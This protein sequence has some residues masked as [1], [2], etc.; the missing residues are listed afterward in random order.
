MLLIGISIWLIL[1]LFYSYLCVKS[2]TFPHEIAVDF[3]TFLLGINL[4]QFGRNRIET[5]RFVYNTF[6]HMRVEYMYLLNK[7]YK[8]WSWNK[9]CFY[10]A[11]ASICIKCIT[12]NISFETNLYIFAFLDPVCCLLAKEFFCQL[13]YFSRFLYF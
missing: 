6:Y 13:A 12:A 4:H 1:Q 7:V 8:I 10:K 11:I 3:C 5:S 9:I 2:G